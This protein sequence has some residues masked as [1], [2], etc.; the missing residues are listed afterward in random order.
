MSLSRALSNESETPLLLDAR[1]HLVET[2]KFSR[3]P[4]ESYS[5]LLL[6]GQQDLRSELL[7]EATLSQ[8][9]TQELEAAAIASGSA[10]HPNF[11]RGARSAATP[12]STRERV[13]KQR[14]DVLLTEERVSARLQA[15]RE[16]QD[17]R[18]PLSASA[19]AARLSEL[20]DLATHIAHAR[21]RRLTNRS[22]AATRLRHPEDVE[23]ASQGR[24]SA[25]ETPL[26]RDDLYLTSER[27]PELA[28]YK[29]H[30]QC[31]ICSGVKSHPVSYLCGHSH[32]YVCIR[33]WLEQSWSCPI[34]VTPMYMPPVRHYGEEDGLAADYPAWHDN[35]AVDYDWDGLIWPKRPPRRI[36][37]SPSPNIKIAIYEL[38]NSFASFAQKPARI[39]SVFNYDLPHSNP[40]FPKNYDRAGPTLES[41]A[42]L[43]KTSKMTTPRPAATVISRRRASAKYRERNAD[44]LREKAR[45]RMARLRQRRMEDVN[46]ATTARAWACEDSRKYREKSANIYSVI[47]DVLTTKI[48]GLGTPMLS[49]T[50]N[51]LRVWRPSR[52]STGIMRG[53]SGRRNG[54][55]S[56][57][58]LKSSRR[59]AA[60]RSSINVP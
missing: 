53:L 12:V 10:W 24:R 14:F 42:A 57:G 8:A 19:Q 4:T 1:G 55:T 59:S 2:G 20:L 16:A 33:V 43:S 7:T 25:R 46:L 6:S 23:R 44:E 54:K 45:Q 27:P 17:S 37:E 52:K 47:C 39:R 30:H 36:V 15:K 41:S 50:A 49:L 26:T 32:C 60:T 3:L 40:D 21:Y 31:G 28:E 34:C 38:G 51:G 35:S 29:L 56:G 9:Q 22:R 13:D 5:S 18:I 11:A 48:H 58:R